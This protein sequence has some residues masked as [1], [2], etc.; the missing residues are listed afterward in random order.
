MNKVE[1]TLRNELLRRARAWVNYVRRGAGY[2][3]NGEFNITSLR[4]A[5]AHGIALEEIG[6]TQDRVDELEKMVKDS[7]L[8]TTPSEVENLR[9]WAESRD[10]S[11]QLSPS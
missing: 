11:G 1:R 7:N 10:F 2:N 9:L 5:I 8:K 6:V 4:D 3:G